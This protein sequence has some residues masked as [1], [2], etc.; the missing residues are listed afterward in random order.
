MASREPK[1]FRSPGISDAG[2]ASFKRIIVFPD[3]ILLARSHKVRG[4]YSRDFLNQ[5]EKD[6]LATIKGYNAAGLAANQIGTAIRM[7]AINL[8]PNSE[9]PAY[10]VYINPEIVLLSAETVTESEGCLSL[11]GL[12]LEI[13]RHRNVGV[14][15]DGGR[16]T[17]TGIVAR[18][19]QHEID[20]LDG[21]LI[22]NRALPKKV[23]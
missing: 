15:W 11:P 3:P 2:A 6:L 8:T 13:E 4:A 9:T 23:V 16:Q 17:F 21:I 12:W 18:A 19:F 14:K 7:I 1:S 5:V 20:H 10:K 22:T